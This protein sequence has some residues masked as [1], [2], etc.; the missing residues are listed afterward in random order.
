M[1]PLLLL[2]GSALWYKSALP[3]AQQEMIFSTSP[4]LKP[5]LSG[6]VFLSPILFAGGLLIAA[7]RP[8][9]ILRPVAWILLL[10]GF[11]YMGSFEFI[12]EGGR[13]PFIIHDFMY[14]NSI[15]KKDLPQVQK[16]G[17]MQTARWIRNREITPENRMAAGKELSTLL[18][19]PCHSEGG[20]LNDIKLQAKKYTPEGMLAFINSMGTANPYMPPFA[21]NREEAAILAEYLTTRMVPRFATVPV[22]ITPVTVSPLPFDP[23]T[24]EYVLLAGP[25]L[26]TILSSEPEESGID[27][28]YGPPTLRAQ[29]IFRDASPSLIM[30]GVT[31]SY[32]LETGKGLL[33]G[34]LAQ[35]DGYFET[36]LTETPSVSTPINLSSS[37][38][39]RLKWKEKS[40]PLP[41]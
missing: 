36:T 34:N 11:L 10:L 8:Q 14:S 28:S 29:L 31:V 6:F 35:L 5:F 20:L 41:K 27:I 1:A 12:R 21:G 13:R 37:L 23:E 7:L 24:S 19:L 38:S 26:G 25:T 4:E 30:D 16:R 3:P 32:S 33:Q 22:D 2:L 17:V 9:A 39:Y 15:L 18:C 40:L